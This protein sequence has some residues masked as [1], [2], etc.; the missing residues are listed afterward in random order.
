VPT[1]GPPC[2]TTAK[3]VTQIDDKW[4]SFEDTDPITGKTTLG[5]YVN[6]PA[7]HSVNPG[8][9]EVIAT[10]DSE[11]FYLRTTYL[12]LPNAGFMNAGRA[13]VLVVR[14]NIDGQVRTVRS[15]L[16]QNNHLPQS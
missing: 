13:V 4:R 14:M 10:C 9:F 16:L 11:G 7:T 8:Y 5:I 12:P 1:S 6:T 3:S 2:S 15:M